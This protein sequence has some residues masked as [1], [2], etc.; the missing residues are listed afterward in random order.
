MKMSQL[1][2]E[3]ALKTGQYGNVW[4]RFV[5]ETYI[6]HGKLPAHSL[7]RDFK[8]HKSLTCFITFVN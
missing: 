1:R 7:Y 8:A 5:I 6:K 2:H 4:E 3:M